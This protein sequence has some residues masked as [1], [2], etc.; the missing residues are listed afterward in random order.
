[1][2]PATPIDRS[3][4]DDTILTSSQIA[5]EQHMSNGMLDHYDKAFVHLEL[6]S[7]GYKYGAPSHARNGFTYAHLTTIGLTQF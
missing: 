7:F 1:M 4:I 2:A 3:T 6:L 5:D